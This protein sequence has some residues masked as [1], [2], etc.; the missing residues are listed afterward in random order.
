MKYFQQF[1]LVK[2]TDYNGNTVNVTNI[3]ERVEIIPSLLNNSLLFYSYDIKDSDTPDIISKKYYNDSYRYWITL[4][5]GQ[6]LD[7]IGDWP[8]PPNLFNDFLIDKYASVTANSLNIPVANVTSSQVLTYTQNTVY[9]YIESVTTIDSTS[10]ESNT[11]IYYIDEATYNNTIV[12]TMNSVLPS[13]AGV[14]QTITKYPQYI[15][16]YEIQANEDKRS[17]NLVNVS[18]AGAL[19]K[20]LSSLLG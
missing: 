16:D 13:G 20:Q 17:I 4:F 18:Y 2:M 1:P 5:G 3:M 12:G 6:R 8:M 11:T 7:P 10:S 14:T 9:H 19:E 15:Y